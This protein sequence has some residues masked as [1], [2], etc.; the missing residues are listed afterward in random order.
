[1]ITNAKEGLPFSVTDFREGPRLKTCMNIELVLMNKI[2]PTTNL[3]TV[4]PHTIKF[5]TQ[6]IIQNQWRKSRKGRVLVMY[7]Y[8]IFG[9]IASEFVIK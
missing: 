7:M 4:Q 1:M 9:I 8:T 6:F 5:I 2:F 3:H